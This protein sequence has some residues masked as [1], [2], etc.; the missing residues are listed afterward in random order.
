M[1]CRR[2]PSARQALTAARKAIRSACPRL[3]LGSGLST[4]PVALVLTVTLLAAVRPELLTQHA[5]DATSAQTLRPPGSGHLF[6]T[7]ELGRD[8][9]SRLVHGTRLSLLI[10]AGATAIGA[11]VGTL[12]G[13]AAGLFGNAVDG[14]LMRCTEVLMAFPELL[15]ALLV[16]T[17]TGPGTANM[18]L[19]VGIAG[20]PGYARVARARVLAVRGAGFVE[21]GLVLGL[22][23][24]HLVTRHIL[25]NALGPLL[26]LAAVGFGGA[27][28]SGAALSYL[29]L[30]P[31]PPS[32]DW[33]TLL[34]DGQEY[35][36]LAWWPTAFPG[37]A[38]TVLAMSVTALGRRLGGSIIGVGR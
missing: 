23:R 3:P 8:V 38:V 30:G 9:F 31:Q 10:G 13:L 29:G 20:A 22:R 14:V 19:S 35:L 34:A 18:V 2:M 27:M 28:V 7:D 16:I 11:T 6:G 33:G 32:T 4:V 25:P 15:L 37:C 21:A 26:V 24:R 5:P 36:Q 1:T 12:I 17:V